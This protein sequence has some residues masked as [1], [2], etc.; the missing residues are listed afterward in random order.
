MPVLA[1]VWSPDPRALELS[2]KNRW[3]ETGFLIVHGL[4]GSGPDH[5]Q[6]WLAG[7]LADRGHS[8]AYP[9]LPDPESPSL[10]SWC[11][12][13][14]GE[15]N[16]LTAPPV[17][18][19]HSLGA[20]TWLHLAARE[21]RT[22][23]ARTLLV[24]P[25]SAGA[26]VAEIAEFVPPPLDRGAVART[27]GTT[28]MVCAPAGDPYCPEGARDLYGSPLGIPVDEI[29]GGAHLNPDAGYGAWPAVERWCR[30]PAA[31]PIEGRSDGDLA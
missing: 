9:N 28:R 19:C 27:A 6:T 21:G 15:L 11:R 24:A 26:G 18:V 1:A 31:V 14:A 23:A 29:P 5:W 30:N 25:P 4:G 2:R 16:A 20:I 7:R 10:E 8:V 22:L 13:L 12:T 17:V 3:I